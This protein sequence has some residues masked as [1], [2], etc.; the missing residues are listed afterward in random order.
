MSAVGEVSRLEKVAFESMSDSTL[1][2]LAIADL[3]YTGLSRKE[4]QPASCR[5]ELARVLLKKVFARLEYEDVKPDAVVMLGDLVEDGTDPNAELDL[6]SIHGELLR[7]GIPFLALPGNHDGPADA[8]N[9]RFATPPGLYKF[10]GYGLVV[11]ND[12]Y[13]DNH[14]TS[15]SV[16]SFAMLKQIR[17]DNPELPLIVLQHAPVYPPIDSHY[18]YRILNAAEIMDSFKKNG[19]VLSLSG[20]YHKGQKARLHEDVMYHTVPSLSEAPFRF[21]IIRIQNGKIEIEEQS[22]EISGWTLMDCHCHTENAFCGTTVDTAPVIA[23]SKAMGISTLCLTEHA[24]QLYFEKHDAMSFKWQSNPD[25]VK[26]AWATPGRGRMAAYRAFADKLR[27][28]FVKIGLELDLFGDGQLL[29]APEDE[30]GWDILIGSIH[31]INGYTQGVTSQTEAEK[32]FMRDLE[33]LVGYNIQ[34]LAH[35]FRF[36]T[37]RGLLRPTRLYNTI[38]DLL[39]DNGVAVEVNFHNHYRPDPEFIRICAEKKV[40]IALAS[41]THEL[42]EAG[43]FWPHIQLLKDAGLQPKSFN[44]YLFSLKNPTPFAAL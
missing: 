14:E 16:E 7:S 38:A 28:P 26:T 41:D 20:H 9:A 22:L 6:I 33:T 18:P 19:V 44:E 23:L 5:G 34:V 12:S 36:F 17:K 2:L 29:L 27:S 3:H 13:A 10:G 25:M 15:R 1:T 21:S 39:N 8:F 30:K 32:L 40:P 42:S 35:P 4:A 37:K 24:F 31:M 11:L 43:E